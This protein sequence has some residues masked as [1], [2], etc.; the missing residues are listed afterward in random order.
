MSAASI[1]ALTLHQPWATLI[2]LGIKTIE[3]RS[4]P[5]PRA[6]I[7]RRL[8]IHAGRTIDPNPGGA[9]VAALRAHYGRGWPGAI[10]KGA[11]VACA[12][13][14]A[15]R[16]VA[17]ADARRPRYVRTKEG[18]VLP[19][20]PYGDFSVGRWLWLLDDVAP[21]EPPAPASGRQRIWYWTP[22]PP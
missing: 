16:Q 8:A 2:A 14:K 21:L 3:T 22:P 10:P 1:P 11:V 5:P 17:G 7:G 4:W 13:V 19:V 6:I 9:V 20:D 12:T 15:A 18:P